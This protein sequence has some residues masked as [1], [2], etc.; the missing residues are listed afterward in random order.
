MPMHELWVDHQ[1]MTAECFG[2][3]S[4]VGGQTIYVQKFTGAV[5]LEM[6]LSNRGSLRGGVLADEMGLGKTYA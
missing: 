1:I 5:C 4:V 6:P 3:K 2:S